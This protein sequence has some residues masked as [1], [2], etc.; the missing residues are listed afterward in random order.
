M[1]AVLLGLH[2]QGIAHT[3]VTVPPL[4][5]F[6]TSGVLMPAA[7]IDDGPWLLDS[8]RILAELG[9]S[10]VRPDESRALLIAFGSSAMRRCDA[11]WSFW[12]RFSKARDGHPMLL[13]RL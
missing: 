11:A 2:D 4:S 9:F 3:Q 12:Y 6:L 8:G 1:Q 7:K 13:R 5:V 10:E